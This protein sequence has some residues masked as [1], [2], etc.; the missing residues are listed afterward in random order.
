MHFIQKGIRIYIVYPSDSDIKNV[1]MEYWN[2]HTYSGKVINPKKI[3]LL[4]DKK[5]YSANTI[6]V[7]II[8]NTLDNIKYNY[9]FLYE[10]YIYSII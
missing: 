1:K 10:Y 4:M 6:L 3:S 2:M 7:K 9:D 8:E 5:N